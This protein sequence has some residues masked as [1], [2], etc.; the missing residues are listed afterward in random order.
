MLWKNLNKP[1]VQY[2]E[3]MCQ[4]LPV[5]LFAESDD[6]TWRKIAMYFPF[7]VKQYRLFL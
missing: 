4:I 6:I 5:F 3:S 7:R 2:S 1:F